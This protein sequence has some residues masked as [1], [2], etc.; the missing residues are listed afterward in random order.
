MLLGLMITL[1]IIGL[2]GL[3]IYLLYQHDRRKMLERYKKNKRE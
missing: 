1:G 2:I 3:L